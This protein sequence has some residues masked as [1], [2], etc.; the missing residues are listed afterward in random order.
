M[1]PKNNS[2]YC[3]GADV[4]RNCG[5][6]VNVGTSGTSTL[7]LLVMNSTATVPFAKGPVQDLRTRTL[8]E[9]FAHEVI[10]HGQGRV[11]GSPTYAHQD[12]IQMTNLFL[13]SQGY[14]KNIYRNGNSHGDGSIL[15]IET[16]NSVPKFAEIPANIQMNLTL[17][18]SNQ[19]L[20][21]WTRGLDR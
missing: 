6:G 14:S 16:A 20:R 11:L 8:A 15:G 4:D 7:S 17:A 10:G 19:Y 5:G 18:K 2:T 21:V 13:H 3:T 1:N 9:L 12:A